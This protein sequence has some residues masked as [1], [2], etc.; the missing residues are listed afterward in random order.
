VCDVQYVVCDVQY[1]VCGV[2]HSNSCS[3]RHCAAK[4]TAVSVIVAVASVRLSSCARGSVRLS[5]SGAAVCGSP[6]MSIFS[7]NVEM[8]VL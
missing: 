3:V 4:R 5:S 8:Y 1:V 6:A 2:R 7:N